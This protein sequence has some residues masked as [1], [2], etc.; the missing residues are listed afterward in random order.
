M[1]TGVGD[2]GV[3]PAR[4]PADPEREMARLRRAAEDFESIMLGTLLKRMNFKMGGGEGGLGASTM[5]EFG[6]QVLAESLARDGGFGVAEVLVRSMEPHVR[7]AA[8]SAKEGGPT[9]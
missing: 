1:I 7:G 9:K 2:L 6:A 4:E 8:A 5:D 3:P